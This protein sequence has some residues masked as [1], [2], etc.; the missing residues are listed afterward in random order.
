[1]KRS[2]KEIRAR[3]EALVE[4][5]REKGYQP[6]P[7][8]ARRFQVS[9]VT[10]RR[11]LVALKNER[12]ITRTHGGALVDDNLRFS[13]FGVRVGINQERKREIGSQ[14]VKLLTSGMSVY[15]DAGTTV[16]AVALELKNSGLQDLRIMTPSIP[17]AELLAEVS[18]I[19][20]FLTGGNV[21]AR[22]SCLVGELSEVSISQWDFDI[23]LLGAEGIDEIGLWNSDEGL[24]RQHRNI[25]RNVDRIVYCLDPSKSSQSGPLFV[26]RW[27]PR[28]ILI[29][30]A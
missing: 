26:C 22:Q 8:L 14:A 7:E 16:Y 25:I 5:I 3:R 1:M 2:R 17:I 28:F 21:L 10:M 18:G 27:D 11:D 12:R 24:V 15:M 19:H 13:V 6:V 9:V 29:S 30:G 23:A 20:V 4:W